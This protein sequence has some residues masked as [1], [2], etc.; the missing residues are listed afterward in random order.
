MYIRMNKCIVS[1]WELYVTY[2]VQWPGAHEYTYSQPGQAVNHSTSCHDLKGDCY[3]HTHIYIIT[4]HN[5][6]PD[7]IPQIRLG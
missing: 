4:E 1:I 5:S 6:L 3:T 7:V 2:V